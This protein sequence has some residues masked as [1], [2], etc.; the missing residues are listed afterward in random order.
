M[1][2]YEL[3]ENFVYS[4]LPSF[5]VGPFLQLCTFISHIFCSAR[6][7]EFVLNIICLMQGIIWFQCNKQAITVFLSSILVLI[8]P[9]CDSLIL[10]F[11]ETAHISVSFKRCKFQLMAD[12]KW[13]LWKQCKICSTMVVMSS[14]E[15]VTLNVTP[16]CDFF[17]FH[18]V[19]NFCHSFSSIH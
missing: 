12:R 18:Y 5:T 3:N 7:F 4:S 19:F 16:L 13:V 2:P 11:Q 17:L 1:W 6:I 10:C 14:G 15:E 8:F 9:I